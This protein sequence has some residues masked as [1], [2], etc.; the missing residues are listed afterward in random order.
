MLN[1]FTVFTAASLFSVGII[2]SCATSPANTS[3]DPSQSNL[4][5]AQVEATSSPTPTQAKADAEPTIY[6]ENE[7]AIK[8]FD[9]VAYFTERTPT[10]GSSQFEYEW[11]GATWQFSSV[12]N[13]DLFANNP[14]QYAPQYGGYCAW[15]VAQGYLAPIDPNAW[16][17]VNERLYLNFNS[18]IQTRW[19]RDIP[20]NIAKANTNWPAVL[21]P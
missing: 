15:A 18:E 8:G 9:P 19:Q 17:I 12:E 13:R 3:S 11:E 7:I 14:S 2:S 21:I 1:K 4:T 20:G 10:L 16:A 5:Q 6:A